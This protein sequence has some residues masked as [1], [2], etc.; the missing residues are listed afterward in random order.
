MMP[1]VPPG[2]QMYGVRNEEVSAAMTLSERLEGVDIVPAAGVAVAAL[3]QAIAAGALRQDDVVLLN[4]TGGGE[5]N[6]APR[7]MT[8]TLRQYVVSKAITDKEI[9]ELLCPV[10]KKNC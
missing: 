2:G 10:L 1:S 5:N 4:I 3:E 9:E 6:L 7:L 8:R